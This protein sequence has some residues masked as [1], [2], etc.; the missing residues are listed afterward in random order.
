MSR[1]VGYG[2]QNMKS[3][4]AQKITIPIGKTMISL[5]QTHMICGSFEAP[6]VTKRALE[7]SGSLLFR[8]LCCLLSRGQRAPSK[9]S[10]ATGDAKNPLLKVELLLVVGD[11][12]NPS[13]KKTKNLL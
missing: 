9:R 1:W 8:W 5:G 6:L 3:S 10:S 4:T 12:A 13:P 11:V 2:F 7:S